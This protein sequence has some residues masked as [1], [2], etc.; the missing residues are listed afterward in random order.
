MF[1]RTE[2][3]MLCRAPWRTGLFALLLA[4][5]VA[6]ACLGGGLLAASGEGMAGL[7]ER[8]TTIALHVSTRAEE[9]KELNKL[10]D[11]TEHGM[12]DRRVLYGGYWPGVHT[13]TSLKETW[14]LEVNSS[15][16][17]YE[18]IIEK[19]LLLVPGNMSEFDKEYSRIAVIATCLEKIPDEFDP[20]WALSGILEHGKWNFR[21]DEVL[22]AHESYTVPETMLHFYD[23]YGNGRSNAH[24][25]EVGRQYL[26]VG[27]I[28]Y[29]N[30]PEEA[31][32]FGT[33]GWGRR[34]SET[35]EYDFEF[36]CAEMSGT[37]EETLARPEN[38]RMAV[39]LRDCEISLNSIT[40]I[41]TLRLNSIPQFNQGDLYITEGR[42]FT[43]REYEQVAPVCIMS[44]KLAQLNDVS[45]GDTIR[46][47]LFD[48]GRISGG[49]IRS[50]W[51]RPTYKSGRTGELSE[52]RE[53]KVVGLFQTPEWQ[54]RGRKLTFSPNTVFI[55]GDP[56]TELDDVALP[57]PGLYTILI[58]N[59]HAE[60]FLAEMEAQKP[61]SSE[62]FVVYDQG[63]SEVLPTM[64]A[65]AENARL[66]AA[67][68]AAVFALAAGVFL[69]LAAARNRHDLG[70]MRSLGVQKRAACG[71]FVLRCAAPALLGSVLGCCAGQLLF[72]RAVSLLGAEGLAVRP[73][74]VQ[75]AVAGGCAALVLLAAVATGAALMK[76]KPRELM[77]E[78]R[79]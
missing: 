56:G 45:V 65:F 15:F 72:A 36:Y 68:C 67:G 50:E 10:A 69:A 52:E 49:A 24:L 14:E 1:T 46:F 19:N 43:A 4:A 29:S 54:F 40:V 18:E 48:A 39:S 73:V 61:G 57:H 6:A 79:G 31:P 16:K 20:D 12:V 66:V 23:N 7:S 34:D 3:R 60:D 59:G 64:E 37:L 53:Y 2:L 22:L 42:D 13:A 5:A 17:S 8:Y 25:Y 30:F 51:S 9:I 11:A 35:K 63:Y 71:A 27:D 47:S 26:I 75:W 78:G 58:E 76:K 33:E 55:P 38:E 74:G 77:R 21:I 44:E 28:G 62:K 32:W 70:V 41:S